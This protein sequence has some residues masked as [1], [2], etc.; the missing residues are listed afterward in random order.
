MSLG[1]G[2]VFE[3][4]QLIDLELSG[5]AGEKDDYDI[6]E[7]GLTL[8]GGQNMVGTTFSVVD[9]NYD[10]DAETV[11]I[12][13]VHEGTTSPPGPSPSATTTTRRCCPSL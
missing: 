12:A 3:F 9:D 5:T 2:S 10:D 4:N 13:V 11:V 6:S 1:S 8:V 7:L